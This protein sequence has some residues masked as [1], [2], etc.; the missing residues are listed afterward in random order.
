MD[1]GGALGLFVWTQEGGDFA[2]DETYERT[3]EHL[4]GVPM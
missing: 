2:V 3:R 1:A 4:R